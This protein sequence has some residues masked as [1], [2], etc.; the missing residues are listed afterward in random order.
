MQLEI[1]LFA[2]LKERAQQDRLQVNIPLPSTVGALI[3]TL[4][5]E[6]P[7]LAPLLP[8]AIVAVN[9]TFASAQTPIQAGDEV[10]IFP[11]VSGGSQA[12]PYPTYFA[13]TP[14]APDLNAIHAHLTQAD[15]GAVVSF[16]GSVRGQT[17]RDGLPAQTL[18]LEYE[19]YQDMAEV[20]MAQI[21]REIWERWP[22]VKGIAIVQRIGR[23]DIGDIT[24]YVA[25]AAGHRDQGV[26]DAARYGIDR[27]K[28][29]VPV[30][31]KE[32]GPDATVWVEGQYRPTEADN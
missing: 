21:A 27:L 29:I 9:K 22:T 15:V 1:R 18:Y 7:A 24:T 28:E 2:T 20:K 11:P 13:L 10:A 25:C 8:I 3:E 30:W 14:T 17:R 32:V 23:L 19:A 12:T 26:F 4:A 16:T 6:Q 5:A 31:K